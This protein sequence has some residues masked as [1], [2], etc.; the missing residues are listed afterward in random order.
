MLTDSLSIKKQKKS[1]LILLV[2]ELQNKS[3]TYRKIKMTI[4]K[5]IS[6]L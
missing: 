3:V 2:D 4:E 5:H 1:Q 6:Q